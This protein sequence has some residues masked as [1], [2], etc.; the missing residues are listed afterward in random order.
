MKK[1]L[2]L[3]AMLLVLLALT[4]CSAPVATV[5]PSPA[6]TYDVRENPPLDGKSL[7]AAVPDFLDEEQQFL[8]RR[9]YCVYNHLFGL[10]SEDFEHWTEA[11]EWYRYEIGE[12]EYRGVPYTRALGRYAKWEDFDALVHSV[13]TDEFWEERN[14]HRY[15]NF[16]GTLFFIYGSKGGYYYNKNFP[17]TFTLVS[18]TEDEICFTLT[19][20]Y[21]SPWPREGETYEDRDKRLESGWDYTWDFP[22]R[23]VR[24]EDGWRFDEFHTAH[25]DQ[26][27]PEEV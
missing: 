25:A 5:T 14:Q 15:V 2:I 26:V 6:P 21:S 10:N 19:G 4:A 20:H 1:H 24:T 7:S 16:D 22:V 13:F 17:D 18:K 23:M 3:P 9:A 27:A 11:D 12:M 8:Y